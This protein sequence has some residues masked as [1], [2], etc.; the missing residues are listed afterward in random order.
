[1]VVQCGGSSGGHPCS[2]WYQR[3]A[4]DRGK[5]IGREEGRGAGKGAG[6]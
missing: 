6:R 5:E 2:Q 1:M 4:Q 3:P